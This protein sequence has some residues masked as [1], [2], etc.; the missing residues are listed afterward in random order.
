MRCPCPLPFRREPRSQSGNRSMYC[1]SLR[2]RRGTR[3]GSRSIGMRCVQSSACR[4]SAWKPPFLLT[5]RCEKQA[6]QKSASTDC[7]FDGARPILAG[8]QLAAV[9]PGI[10]AAGFQVREEP[11]GGGVF[12]YVGDE[13]LGPV[14]RSEAETALGV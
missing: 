4:I 6:K 5:D 1:V 8:Q 2:M 12:L 3:Q 11:L 10:E 9:E 7:L 14:A 13:Y